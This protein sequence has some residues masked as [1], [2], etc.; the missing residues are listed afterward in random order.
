LELRGV[1]DVA[2]DNNGML[3]NFGKSYCLGEK[4]EDVFLENS[5]FLPKFKRIFIP[6]IDLRP[7]SRKVVFNGTLFNDK[8][9]ER[10]VFV[11][12]SELTEV[13]ISNPEKMHMEGKFVKSAYLEEYKNLFDLYFSDN[14]VSYDSVIFDCRIKPVVYGP[15]PKA[16]DIKLIFGW[17][18]NLIHK[19]IKYVSQK[20][21]F[22]PFEGKVKS[23]IQNGKVFKKG[24]EL[25]KVEKRKLLASYYLPNSLG[26]NSSKTL[27]CVTRIEGEYISKDDVIAERLVSGGLLSKRI[28]SDYDGIVNLNRASL[29]YVNILSELGLESVLASFEGKV[30][31]VNMASGILVETDSCE[32]PIFYTNSKLTGNI[33]GEL[34]VLNDSASV[35]SP[36]KLK[37]SLE[38]KVVFA[39][40]FLYPELAIE[41][42][43]KG[44]KFIIVS[45]MNYDDFKNLEVPIGVLS[46]FGNIFFDSIKLDFFKEFEGAQVN[47]S[48][49]EQKLDFPVGLND[50][51]GKI[52][53]QNYYTNKIQ[54]GDI[55]K[56]V[57]LDYFGVVGEVTDVNEVE[58]IAKILT[59]ENLTFST[60]VDN[61]EL[62]N[63]EYSIM[64]TRII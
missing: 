29:G 49:E 30:K 26:I 18:V 36:S 39:G 62:Y 34:R 28:L 60:N 22:I 55:V 61:L 7:D 37:E 42:F 23:V 27:D 21:I 14:I 1:F 20:E 13:K 47:V 25:F 56:S 46:G 50:G 6:D 44:C 41:L 35:S 58:K 5:V 51:I 52:F 19:G 8:R 57:D 3:Y 17:E 9:I 15:D 11:L 64:R 4:T 40:R 32:V 10:D 48:F 38:G 12:S 16:N 43:K 54:K 24:E 2:L 59:Q 63:E 31:D 33:F 53:E 45:S